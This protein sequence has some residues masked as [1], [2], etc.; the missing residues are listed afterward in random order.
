MKITLGKLRKMKREGEK[1]IALTAYDSVFASLF[2][3]QAHLLLIGDSLNMIVKGHA[4]TL[5]C[6]VEEIIY[7][8]KAVVRSTQ[9]AFILADMPYGS[10]YNQ[11]VALK[12]ALKIM[13]ESGADAIKLELDEGKIPLLKT[14]CD[15]G[16]PV[17]AHIGLKPQFV[18][19]EGGYKIAGK[20]EAA[21]KHLEEMAKRMEEAG[22]FGL[23]LEGI[24]ADVATK[25]TKNACIPTIGIG[26]G[27]QTDGQILVY[28][29][30]LGFYKDFAPKFVR[31]FM[32]GKDLVNKAL[33]EYAK[34]VQN[35]SFP[36]ED[37]S[38]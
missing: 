28:S 10:Y 35:G 26:S 34:S 18:R 21:A 27:N 29:D 30:A 24:K 31:K 36:N 7:H 1:I 2:D 13:K 12:N 37:E 25:I 20:D 3:E 33:D 6:S 19:F 15:E 11:D 5:G 8:T 9:N 14:L 23:L 4:D 17:M 32:E 22:A 38:Y 16:I